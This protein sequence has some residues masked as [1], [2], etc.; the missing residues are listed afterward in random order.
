M[1]WYTST[2]YKNTL[3]ALFSIVAVNV[4][5]GC[6][7]SQENKEQTHQSS[8]FDIPTYFQKQISELSSTNPLILKTVSTNQEVETKETHISDWNNEL[9]SFVAI[10]L[11]K[12]AYQDAVT[13]DSV[14]NIVTYSLSGKNIDPTT[15]K[16]NYENERIHSLEIEKTT[17]NFLY[18]TIEK[19][20]FQAG[21]SYNIE[22]TQKVVLLGTNEYTIKGEFK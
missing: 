1:Y 6:S 14:N 9:S 13:K 18:K 2:K 4:F 8:Y 17:S 3:T 5:I 22:K 20:Q 16:I 12:P 21:K 7:S 19:L 15:V 10:D 11:N